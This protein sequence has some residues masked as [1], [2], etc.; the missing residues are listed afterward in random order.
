MSA[1]A[2]GDNFPQIILQGNQGVRLMQELE[3]AVR[4]VLLHIPPLSLDEHSSQPVVLRP[5]AECVVIQ[6]RPAD[7]FDVHIAQDGSTTV[8]LSCVFLA[9]FVLAGY[10][11]VSTRNGIRRVKLSTAKLTPTQHLRCFLFDF[12]P[13]VHRQVFFCCG[14]ARETYEKMFSTFDNHVFRIHALRARLPV[15]G[16]P[17]VTAVV[18]KPILTAKDLFTT[19]TPSAVVSI[20]ASVPTTTAP[21]SPRL[22]VA[23]TP[24][25]TTSQTPG[26]SQTHSAAIE[27]AKKRKIDEALH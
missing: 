16:Q 25:S 1:V 18:A 26:A 4:K 9:P 13:L 27:A 5:A 8:T 7:V 12:M 23:T 3:S 2:A 21:V 24:T 10:R 6:H 15:D 20:P 14:I 11:F 17:F 22:T 19:V